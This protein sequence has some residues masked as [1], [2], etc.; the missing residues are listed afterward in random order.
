MHGVYS[1]RSSL[2]Q[3]NDIATSLGKQFSSFHIQHVCEDEN[4][5]AK[6]LANTALATRK[7][8]FVDDQNNWLV[9]QRDPMSQVDVRNKVARWKQPDHPAISCTIDSTKTYLLQFDGGSRSDSIGMGMV[10]YDGSQE[11]WSGWKYHRH[12][13]SNNVAEYLGALYG[14]KAASSLG[15]KRLILEGDSLLIV[16]QLN[17]KRQTREKYMDT[18]KEKALEYMSEF[19]DVEIRHIYRRHNARADWLANFAMDNAESGGF[20][21]LEDDDDDDSLIGT[22]RETEFVA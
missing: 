16:Q 17:G 21:Y 8:I 11:I 18:F 7:S 4:M 22:V 3:L 15:V 20:I 12:H 9:E 19:D 10:M 2:E 6:S 1:A 13:A 14:L 5:R